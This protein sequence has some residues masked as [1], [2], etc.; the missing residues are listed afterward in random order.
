MARIKHPSTPPIGVAD[1]LDFSMDIED[2]ISTEPR[3]PKK[4]PGSSS[5][6][7]STTGRTY[8]KY[9]KPNPKVGKKG[10]VIGHPP[11]DNDKRKIQF[12]VSCTPAEK[13]E[14]KAAAL[15]DGRKF[16]DFINNAIKEYI[17]NHQLK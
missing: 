8:S 15:A 2:D 5:D 9:Y 7:G 16:P 1:G 4:E 14:Y 17:R 12:S 13:E 11:V 10:G 3:P 6:P